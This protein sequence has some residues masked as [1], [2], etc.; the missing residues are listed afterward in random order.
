[1]LAS[2]KKSYDK[3]RQHIKKQRYY[4]GKKG[5]SSQSYGFFSSHVQ[6]WELDDKEDW[7]PKNWCFQTLVLEK[8]LESPLEGIF[9]ESLARRSNQSILTEINPEYSLEG[10]MLKL[11]SFSHL[12][13][14]ANLLG[15]NPG[16]DAGKDKWQEEKGTTEDEIVGWLHQL[17]VHEFEQTP[18]ENEGQESLAC[19]SPWGHKES[20][21]WLS[22]WTTTKLFCKGSGGQRVG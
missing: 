3:P 19:Y 9:Q 7:V 2:W 16:K 8:T 1:M 18:G 20:Q 22:Y 6:M 15:K 4:F 10:L 21:T 11:Q 12:M 13:W 14:R 5:L 17:N